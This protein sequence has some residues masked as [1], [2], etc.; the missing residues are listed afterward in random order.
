MLLHFCYEISSYMEKQR[1]ALS[2]S[3][4]A[5]INKILQAG[6]CIYIYTQNK[7]IS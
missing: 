6:W 2:W 4:Q 7:F 3:V 1:E 5:A